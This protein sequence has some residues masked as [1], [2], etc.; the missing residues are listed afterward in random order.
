[1]AELK[2]TNA[3]VPAFLERIPD[4]SRRRDCLTVLGL[5]KRA[6]RTEPKVWGD[7]MIGF[8]RYHYVYASGHE[9]DCFLTGFAPRKTDLTLYITSGVDNHK[10][11]MAKLGKH[12]TG[13]GC[14]YIKRLED[15]DLEVLETLIHESVKKVKSMY[16]QG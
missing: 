8:G 1:M 10:P 12:K 4:A 5:M 3:S 16:P 9:G 6:T 7:R 13:K 2:A 11:L 15:V 14:L